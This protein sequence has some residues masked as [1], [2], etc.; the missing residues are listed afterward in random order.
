MSL[1][2]NQGFSLPELM[3]AA[4]ILGGLSLGFMKLTQNGVESSKRVESGSQIDQIKNEVLGILSNRQACEKT[5][6]L[7][8][9]F[10]DVKGGGIKAIS[11][12]KDKNNMVRF[13][14]GQT[15]S[16]GTKLQSIEV[17]NFNASTVTAS[18]VLNFKYNLNSQHEIQKVKLVDLQLELDSSN[19]LLNCVA[20]A[21][22]QNIDPRQI[23][24]MVVGFD[25]LGISYFR[26][27]ACQFAVASCEKVGGVWDTGTNKCVIDSE[28]EELACKM[29]NKFYDKDKTPKCQNSLGGYKAFPR[30]GGS[31]GATYE[32]TCPTGMGIV[33]I[34]GRSGSSVDALGFTCREIDYETLKPT[35]FSY[36]TLQM[37]GT[38]GT[39]FTLSCPAGQFAI[40]LGGRSGTSIDR[41]GIYCG[42]YDGTGSSYYYTGG[43]GGTAF[44]D[45][46]SS[47]SIL[48]NIYLRAG[49]EVDRVQ[50]NCW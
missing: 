17:K 29:A 28:L 37:G 38:G 14:V 16:G 46:C 39:A 4:A 48:R 13:S 35:G 15:F 43:S 50:G 12:I 32:I 6:F 2:G 23:C 26:S 47:N 41:I 40:G 3:M 11:S 49:S 5:F 44:S 9:D 27:G 36:N 30:Y 24:D 42:N 7:H 18:L 1:F 45:M 20:M 8:Q 21:G 10:T 34:S 31:G 33:A 22:V 25:S 19:L